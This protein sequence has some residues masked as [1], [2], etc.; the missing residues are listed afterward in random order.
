MDTAAI[1]TAIMKPEEKPKKH[2]RVV[3]SLESEPQIGSFGAGTSAPILGRSSA[4]GPLTRPRPLGG[5]NRYIN[6]I[7]SQRS[8]KSKDELNFDIH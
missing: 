1:V 6:I 4:N 3:V 5:S 2:L 7:L 8:R